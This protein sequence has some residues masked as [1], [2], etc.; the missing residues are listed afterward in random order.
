VLRAASVFGDRFWRG[1]V[2]ALVGR[3]QAEAQE[4]LD[5][6]VARE[7]IT[8]R[9]T[10]TLPGETEYVFRHALVRE[11]AYA[12]LT[13]SDR[14]L[15]H[16]LAG[17]WLEGIAV[18]S[19]TVL[20]E[21]GVFSPGTRATGVD[22]IA[23]AEHFDLGR[24]PARAIVWYR[25]GAEQALEGNDFAAAIA[26]AER[27]IA[28][29]ASDE[30][31]GAMRFL[32]AAAH[33]WRTEY[34]A[35]LRAGEEAMKKLVPGSAPWF[36]AA[37]DVIEAASRLGD[38][39]RARAFAR[40]ASNVGPAAGAEGEQLVTLCGAAMKLTFAGRLHYANELFQQIDQL[41]RDPRRLPR[42]VAARVHELAALRAYYSGDPS[43]NLT[44]LEAA[45]AAY[46][47]AGDVRKCC[48]VRGYLG[49]AHVELGDYR[50]AEDLLREAL[51]VAERL[52][53]QGV[54]A[55]IRENLALA[56]ARQGRLADA[57]EAGLAAAEAYA[58]SQTRRN[59]GSAYI[60]LSIIAYL[61][62]QFESAEKLARKAVEILAVA[63]PAR[64]GAL[65]QVARSLLA[66]G[67]VDD[68]L[69][70][71]R[72]A[73]E[74]LGSLGSADEGETLIRLVYAEALHAVGNHSAARAAILAARDRLH[75]RAEKIGDARW[76]DSFL[77]RVP[78]NAR[79][80]ELGRVWGVGVAR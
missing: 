57:R 78:E 77:H 71:A 72:E 17:A 11:A 76:R 53:L 12:M 6:L 79:T 75:E 73:M 43:G 15:G 67:R 10:A 47:D 8:R 3:R 13:E 64:A 37:G 25:R 49:F 68:A 61:E 26:R 59:E 16:R 69:A 45:L 21:A 30:A 18:S 23:L 46:Q 39:A 20:V 2:M 65:A 48:Q 5:D 66:Q 7:V 80:L 19:D 52:G 24:E 58:A 29:G 38:I 41:A 42:A 14:A 22:A 28:C 74:L 44:G 1:G 40:E 27:G 32:Q 35:A 56:L 36:R 9:A 50:R 63:P 62:G 33:N 34:D 31:L 70:T 4:L 54:A 55:N 51:P 60:Y